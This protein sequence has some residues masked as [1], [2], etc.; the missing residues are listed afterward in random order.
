MSK[1]D[2]KEGVIKDYAVVYSGAT[3][4]SGNPDFWGGDIPWLT[5]KDLSDNP[6]IYTQKGARSITQKG[7]ESCSTRLL[8]KALFYYLPVRRLD[9]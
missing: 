1:A 9:M 5:P 6:A 8:P 3:P 2:W 4:K 7:Y